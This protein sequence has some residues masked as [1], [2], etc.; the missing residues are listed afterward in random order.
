MGANGADTT[1]LPLCL[2]QLLGSMFSPHIYSGGVRAPGPLCLPLK[3]K[4]HPAKEVHC[5]IDPVLPLPDSA[6]RT[7]DRTS[8]SADS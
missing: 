6:S 8:Q 7:C 2:C 1:S 4:R 5:I 3:V